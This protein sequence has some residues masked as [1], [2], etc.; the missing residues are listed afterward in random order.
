MFA[1]VVYQVRR[2]RLPASDA[3]ASKSCY[4]IWL[5]RDPTEQ[6]ALQHSRSR[7]ALS[8]SQMS[9]VTCDESA[10]DASTCDTSVTRV[11]F[12]DITNLKRALHGPLSDVKVTSQ[13][14]SARGKL[15]D[16]TGKLAHPSSR[17]KYAD[18]YEDLREIGK[19]AFGTVTLAF[20]KSTNTQV[21]FSNLSL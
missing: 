12:S 14:T 7:A 8:T 11:S 19:G 21:S 17:R 2:V 4:C 5:S 1:G 20:K 3:H 16:A 9:S 18:N 13:V 6:A 15:R 10:S